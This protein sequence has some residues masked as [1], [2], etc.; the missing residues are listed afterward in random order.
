MSNQG[1]VAVLLVGGLGTRLRSVVSDRPKVLAPV[2]GKPFLCYLLDTLHQ[3]DL[4]EVILCTG[5]LGEQVQ[6]T[7]GKRYKGLRLHY[8]Q[9]SHP[10]G[11]AGA[12]RLAA[13]LVKSETVLIMNGDSYYQTDMNRLF[14]AHKERDAE[15]TILLTTVSNPSRYGRVVLDQEDR[16]VQFGEKEDNEA[17]KQRDGSHWI[18]SGIYLFSA[19]MLGD[20]VS[21]KAKS[22][23]HEVFPFWIGK[24]LY[25]CR[26]QGRFLDVG[27][28]E[29]YDLAENF[30][31][32]HVYA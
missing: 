9:E 19:K 12:L 6:A 24:G 3:N 13:P 4:T 8:S 20:V 5:Y 25:G 29:S 22:L 1:V 14:S 26:G 7:L 10:L 31:S 27:T 21:S 11:T 18:S 15:A 2:R 32:Q 17:V 16:I 28:P 23:E 30:F